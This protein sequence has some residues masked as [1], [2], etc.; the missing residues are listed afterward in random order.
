MSFN[1]RSRV[2]YVDDDEDT[3]DMLS[4][5]LRFSLIE[6]KAV[7][8]AAQALSLIQA[9]RFDLY[10][11]DTSLPDLDGFELCRR[12]RDFDP[13]TPILF[14]SGAGYEGDKKKGIKAGANAYVTKPDLAS[15]I[16]SITKFVSRAQY[17][18]A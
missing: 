4:T 8:T 5:L 1:P 18:A 14:F 9:E 15:L 12:M 3:R 2:L 16:G 11:L 10:L 7:G 6:A 17:A 13:H